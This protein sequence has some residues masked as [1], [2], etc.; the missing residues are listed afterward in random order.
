MVTPPGIEPG[1]PPWKGDV[2]TAWPSG[3]KVQSFAKTASFSS[4]TIADAPKYLSETLYPGSGN[5]IWTGD[6][7]GMN[8]ML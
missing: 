3:Q 8:R 2:L 7:S 5:W 1:L 6:T 4:S